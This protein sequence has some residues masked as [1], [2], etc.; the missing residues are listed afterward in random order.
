MAQQTV[1]TMASAG[2]GAVGSRVIILGL[3]FM[4]DC[5]D[6]RNS[7]VQDLLIE[8]KNYGCEL[9]VHDPFCDSKE[10]LEKYGISLC[11]ESDLKPAHAVVLAVSHRHYID[12]STDNWKA[13][14]VNN[15]IIVDIK[16]TIPVNEL[17]SAGQLV[18]R[19]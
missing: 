3:T 12:W 6:L 18:W 16:N 2:I 11:D 13:L 14:L 19:L 5:P 15:G 9:Q 10:A 8:L 4:E 17:E 1:Q 7:H